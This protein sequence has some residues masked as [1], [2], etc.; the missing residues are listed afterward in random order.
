MVY[1]LKTKDSLSR[2]VAAVVKLNV[3]PVTANGAARP[4][5]FARSA[6]VDWVAAGVIYEMDRVAAESV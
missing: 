4:R 3:G 5:V 6:R 2:R 1:Q